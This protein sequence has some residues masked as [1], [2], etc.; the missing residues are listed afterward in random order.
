MSNL[1]PVRDAKGQKEHSKKFIISCLVTVQVEGF[2]PDKL[3]IIKVAKVAAIHGLRCL[4]NVTNV[5]KNS[6]CCLP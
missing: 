5:K 2:Y 6:A 1:G 3:L 4:T